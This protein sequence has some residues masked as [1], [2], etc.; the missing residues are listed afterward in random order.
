M[1]FIALATIAV[2]ATALTMTPALA[3]KKHHRMHH[4]YSQMQDGWNNGHASN[5]GWNN[6]R[7]WNGGWN[8]RN[9]SDPSLGH[10]SADE[11]SR[12]NGRCVEDL[13]Y[14]R[15]EACGW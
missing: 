14:G 1:K 10:P 7:G 6:G 3:K 9:V 4:Q 2:T 11:V 12:W 13:G 15:Y 8:S 5:G